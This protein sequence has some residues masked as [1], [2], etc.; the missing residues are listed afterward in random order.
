MILFLFSGNKIVLKIK[1]V[2]YEIHHNLTNLLNCLY[3]DF[4]LIFVQKNIL[5]R[6]WALQLV[7]KNRL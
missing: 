5:L 1:L 7:Y 2:Y 3:L 6:L 4:V